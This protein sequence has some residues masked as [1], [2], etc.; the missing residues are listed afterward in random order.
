M[1]GEHYQLVGIIHHINGNTDSLHAGHY[2][3]TVNYKSVKYADDLTVKLQN[4][5][6]LS[7]SNTAYIVFYKKLL[8][9]ETDWHERVIMNSSPLSWPGLYTMDN[10]EHM[11]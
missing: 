1:S 4:M 9:V 7:A 5:N 2:K 6:D 3:A 10:K 11:S 8:S